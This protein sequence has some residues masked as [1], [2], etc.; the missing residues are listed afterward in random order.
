MFHT[1]LH[2][3]RIYSLWNLSGMCNCARRFDITALLHAAQV[4][5]LHILTESNRPFY[6]TEVL[7]TV[8][9]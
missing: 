3:Q 6:G 2:L 5:P 9:L 8:L 4:Q 7:S 1:K